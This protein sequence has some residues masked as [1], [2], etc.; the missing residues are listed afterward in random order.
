[1]LLLSTITKSVYDDLNLGPFVDS[2][3]KLNMTKSTFTQEVGIKDGVIIQINYCPVMI[4]LVIAD[5]PEVSIAPIILARP[6]LRTIKATIGALK[7][8]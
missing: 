1:V 2:E 6:F 3:I 7:E 4:D 5:M 8:M